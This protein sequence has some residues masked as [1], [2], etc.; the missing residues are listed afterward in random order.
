MTAYGLQSIT[1]TVVERPA[2]QKGGRT[3][4]HGRNIDRIDGWVELSSL[5]RLQAGLGRGEYESAPEQRKQTVPS[6]ERSFTEIRFASFPDRFW[7][8]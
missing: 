7:E 6:N 5:E 2:P 1:A 4:N 8:T 3:S